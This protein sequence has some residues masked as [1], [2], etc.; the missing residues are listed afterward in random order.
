[1]ARRPARPSGRKA[2]AP[3]ASARNSRSG[4][5]SRG[6]T[7]TAGKAKAQGNTRRAAPRRPKARK[8]AAS[9]PARKRTA[10]KPRSVV[11][12]RGKSPRL[13]RA[14]RVLENDVP[15]PPSS[16]DLKRQGSAARTGR[17]EI[18][19]RRRHHAGMSP[20]ITAGDVDADLESAYFSGEEA[21][22]GDNP[23]PDQ[24]IVDD[25]GRALGV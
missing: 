4:A 19:E 11:Q 12:V 7:A 2:K 6:R 18:E 16:L 1:M 9:A 24:G 21:A 14:R 20:A 22:G 25:I 23:T 15:T 8:A 3:R 5:A 13:D 10:A 17:H